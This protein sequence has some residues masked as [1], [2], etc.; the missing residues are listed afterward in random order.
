[1]RIFHEDGR[2]T[3]AATPIMSE[4]GEKTGLW[5]KDT[6]PDGVIDIAAWN[7]FALGTK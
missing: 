6:D 1:M 2:V 7:G 4:Q 3:V 5:T